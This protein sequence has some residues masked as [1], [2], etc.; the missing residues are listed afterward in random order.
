MRAQIISSTA[1]ASLCFIQLS[2]K[3]P[4]CEDKNYIGQ[5][6]FVIESV[7]NLGFKFQLG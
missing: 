3:L 2:F 7:C 6:V 4:Y 1:V 5:C